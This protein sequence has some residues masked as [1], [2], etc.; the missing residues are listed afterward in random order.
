MRV[1]LVSEVFPPRAGGAGWSARALAL[2]LQ[3]A[4]H[5]IS[6]ATTSPGPEEIDGIPVRRLVT[7]GRKRSALPRAFA[8][9]VRG[10]GNSIV[11]A[12]HFLSALGC[13]AAGRPERVVVTVRDTWPTCFWAAPI[14]RGALCPS[15]GA[16]PMTRCLEGRTRLPVPFSWGAIPYMLGDLS[17]RRAALRRAGAVLGVSDAVSRGL[18]A[19]GIPRV[20]TVPNIVDAE[21]TRR[22]AV[23]PPTFSLPDRFLLYVG[24]L[25]PNK[26][27]RF[28]VPAVAGARSGLPLVVLG[29]GSQARAVA[30]EA[31]RAGVPLIH[32]GWADRDD[33]L[34]TLARA[35]AL[36]F[37]SLGPESLS[38]VLL[39]AL[40]LGTPAA[41][42]NTGGTGELVQ[43]EATGLLVD[44]AG[45]LAGAVARLVDDDR[46]RA[47]LA[48]GAKERARAF[49]PEAL[50][51][52][53][54]AV[55][56]RLP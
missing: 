3:S 46:L 51:P 53:Y 11:H 52:R 42:M 19:A 55:Y 22:L 4:G 30:R 41:A 26:G 40:A 48:E 34:R 13:V 24:K 12:Q 27:V 2:A 1:L 9:A 15:C 29:D 7:S 39:E 54:V 5:E 8:K 32:L 10:S 35:T 20:L 37:P 6:V 31:E 45:E 23:P 43:N 44:D 38:R 33:V 36:V 18:L 17:L 21:E 28:L 25:E 14:S 16:S 47:R 49:S 50:V 56:G